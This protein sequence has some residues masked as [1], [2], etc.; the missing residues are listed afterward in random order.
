MPRMSDVEVQTL[1]LAEKLPAV[2]AR[3]LPAPEE[4][5]E[6]QRGEWTKLVGRMP[7]DWFSPANTALIVQLCRHIVLARKVAR[8]LES[9]VSVNGVDMVGLAS[10]MKLQQRESGII[11]VLMTALRLTPRAIQPSRTSI[12]RL[13][14]VAA[15][16]GE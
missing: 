5:T 8:I 4:L 7:A 15:P 16:W 6:E 1:R 14:A 11:K 13:H 12:K 9:M 10:I 2:E 3:R